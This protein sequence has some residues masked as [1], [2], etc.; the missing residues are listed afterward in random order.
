MDQATQDAINAVKQAVMDGTTKLNEVITTEGD[1][2]KQKVQDIINQLPPTTDP[3]VV[4]Q[5]TSLKESVTNSFQDIS[6]G[7]QNLSDNVTAGSGEGGGETP[8]S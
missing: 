2:I 3:E 1:E 4:S 7:I 8:V 5:L 6:G